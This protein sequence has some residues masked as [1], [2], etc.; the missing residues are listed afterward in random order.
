VLPGHEIHEAE[1]IIEDHGH[2]LVVE[3]ISAAGEIAVDT[4]PRDAA[5]K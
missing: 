5:A 4:D 1:R 2:Y 3:K